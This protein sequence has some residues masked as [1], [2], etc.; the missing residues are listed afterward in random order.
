MPFMG[1][2]DFFGNDRVSQ[3]KTKTSAAFVSVKTDW[4]A[5]ELPSKPVAK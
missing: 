4:R 2:L 5:G 1:Y 3:L